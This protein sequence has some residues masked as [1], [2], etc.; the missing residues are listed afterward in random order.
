MNYLSLIILLLFDIAI[1]QAQNPKL[2]SLDQLIRKATTDTGRINLINKKIGLLGQINIDSAI[3]LGLRTVESAK[4]I[5]YSKGEG[6]TRI[7]LAYSYSFKGNYTAAKT[8][9]KTAKSIYTT[10]NDTLD[11]IKVYNTYGSM[12]GMQSKYDSAIAFFEKGM[13]LAEHT[14][15]KSDLATIY[16]NIGISYDMLSNRPQALHFQQKALTMAESQKD[17]VTQAYCQVNMANSYK[18]MG[19]MKGAEKR[20]KQAIKLSNLVGIKNVELY[21]YTNLVDIYNQLKAPQKAYEM[22]IKAAALGKETGDEAIQATSLS[23]AATNLAEQKKFAEAEALNKQAM[24]IAQATGQPLNIHQAYAA[25]GTILK[26]QDKYA[27]AIPYYEKSFDVLKDADIY[28]SQTGEIYG[29]LSTSYE[30]TGDYRRALAAYKRASA[31]SD[32][33]RS[34]ENVRKATELSMTY[35]FNKKQ[36]LAQA[37]HQQ[38]NALAQSRQLALGAG[39]GLMLILAAV[40]FYAYRTKQKANVLLEQQKEELE[41]TLAKLRNTQTQLIQSEKMASLGELTA[42]IAHEIQNPLNFVNNFSEVSTELLSEIQ[43]ER[44]KAE[45]DEE[46]EEEILGDLTGNLEKINHH[47][48]RAS[49]IVKSMLEHS[50]NHTGKK[51]LTDLNTLTDEYLRLA[52]HGFRSKDKELTIDLTTQFDTAPVK[53]EVVSQEIGRVLLNLFNNAFYAVRQ[54]QQAG[55]ADYHPTVQVSTRHQAGQVEI[56]VRDN[57]TGI[58]QT[59]LDKIFQPFFTTKPTG[60]GTGLG[61]SLSYDIITKGHSGTL[62]VNTQPGEFSEFIIRLPLTR[63]S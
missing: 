38:Q 23:K 5:K 36:Q 16:L 58:P 22:A 13:S 8:N 56:C 61:L 28:D 15:N 12:Y 29:E 48:K 35:E 53:V 44:K 7:R 32:S 39:M 41:Q 62:T 26:K 1:A 33:V 51:Q 24:A 40:S 63:T 6:L 54:K 17:Y 45:R 2:D 49:S 31:I 20:Y 57:G 25:M 52:Y 19:D 10:L 46:L 18:L 14:T 21:A 47:G 42:G 59:V 50:R 43:A 34:K 3:R 60:Q 4:R 9:L 11:L 27:A 30:K 55:V 37:E